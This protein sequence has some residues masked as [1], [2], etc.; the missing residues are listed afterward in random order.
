MRNKN[1]NPATEVHEGE[2]VQVK[3]RRKVLYIGAAAMVLAVVLVVFFTIA[4]SY[5]GRFLNHTT[6]N[7]VNC[8][9]KTV[10]EVNSALNE[11]AQNYSLKLKEREGQE[12]TITGK[13]IN[14]TY[15]DQGEYRSCWMMCRPTLGLGRCFETPT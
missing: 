10:E 11:Q 9:G 13:E 8:S 14:L 7:G 4:N 5:R 3:S 12:E 15:A 1:Q 6:I 2:G